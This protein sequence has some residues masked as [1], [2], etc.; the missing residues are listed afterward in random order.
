MKKK[1]FLAAIM[2]CFIA[3]CQQK[4]PEVKYDIDADTEAIAGEIDSLKNIAGIDEEQYNAG[5]RAILEKYY[6]RHTDDSLGLNLFQVLSAFIWDSKTLEA[7]YDKASDL[8][9]NDESVKKYI[10]LSASNANT[11]AGAKYVDI[12]G[13]EAKTGEEIAVSQ[14][15]GKGQYV[16]LDFWASWCGPCRN[17]ITN[18]LPEVARK[19]EGKLT[20]IGI[21]VWEKKR[22]DLDKVMPTLPITWPVIY[23]S[24]LD[25]SPSDAYGVSSIPTLVLIAPDGTILARGQM[26]DIQPLLEKL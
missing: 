23:A 3:G 19:Y 5:Y 16:L 17:C 20:I 12:K 1:L 26:P 25:P 22:E 13:P 21:D 7:E 24:E 6:Q 2:A 8:I 9:R 18:E 15:L 4:A 14:Y 11:A 10:L